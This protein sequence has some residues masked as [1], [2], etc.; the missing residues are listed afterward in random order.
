M[1]MYGAP[2][3]HDLISVGGLIDLQNKT[4]ETEESVPVTSGDKKSKGQT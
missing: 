1:K 4:N 3:S 2:L